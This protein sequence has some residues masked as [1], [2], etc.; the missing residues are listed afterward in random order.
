MKNKIT[1]PVLLTNPRFLI[2]GGGNVALHK[3]KVLCKNNIPF[4]LISPD[5]K[6]E[7]FKYTS[8]IKQK[9]FKLKYI[10]NHTYIINATGNNKITKKLIKYKKKNSILLNI[11]N[12]PKYCDFYFMA[13]TTN[14][15]LKI[16]VSSNGYSPKIAIKYRDKCQKLIPKNI[17]KILLKSSKIR[18][19]NI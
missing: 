4:K 18:K 11:S 2:I 17:N 15:N 13:L 14:K 8:N 3:A 1:L 7:I 10:K 16:A 5:I 6:K 19:S 9:K 12:K